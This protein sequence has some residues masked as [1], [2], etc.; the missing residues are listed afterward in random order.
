M[1]SSSQPTQASHLRLAVLLLAAGEGSRLGKHPKALLRK[2]G[3]TLL[4]RFS[5][6]IEGFAPTEYIVVTGFHAEA[7]ESEIEK[8]NLSLTHPIK[9]IQN[10]APERGHASS[11]RLGL[12]SFKGI[13][14]VLL[15]ALS[16][17]PEVGVSEVQELLDIFL[18]REIGEEIILPIVE[19]KRGNPVLFSRKAISDVLA[20]PGMVCREYMVAHPDQVRVMLTSNR[21]FVTDVDTPEDIQL[22]KLS[23][24]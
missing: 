22:H 4:Q 1:I 10:P 24:T 23:L 3:N 5:S 17:Q 13:F 6:A 16:D 18:R 11:V 20:T 14:D 7:I 12:E 2:D 8:L 19:G 15:V 21:A 9:A